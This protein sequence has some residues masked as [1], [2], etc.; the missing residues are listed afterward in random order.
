MNET[1]D[2]NKMNIILKSV[3]DLLCDEGVDTDIMYKVNGS[4]YTLSEIIDARDDRI[5]ELEKETKDLKTQWHILYA[6]INQIT[7]DIDLM[8]TRVGIE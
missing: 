5:H 4:F 8:R 2:K 6:T 7:L 3:Q 1:K